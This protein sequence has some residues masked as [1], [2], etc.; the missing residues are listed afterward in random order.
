[1]EPAQALADLPR[2]NRPDAR[3]RLQI[4]LRRPDDRLQVAEAGDDLPDEVLGQ[5]GDVRQDPEAARRDR[6]VERVDVA[7]IADQLRQPLRFQQLPVRECVQSFERELRPRTG[8]VR[9]VV[10]HYGGTL[11]GHLADQLVQLHP[12]QPRLG[13]EL[14]AVALDLLG[15][16][17]RHLRAL[18]HDE[19]IVEHDGVLKL[20]RGQPRQDLVE[21]LPVGLERRER[22]IRL[23]E[24]LGHGIEL[25]TRLRDVHGD[26]GALLGDGDHERT[27]LLRDTLGSAVPRARLVRRD[28]RVGHQL[29][30]RV[31]DLRQR[32]RDDDRSVH[33][34]ELVE[35]LRREGLVEPHPTGE[36][37]RELTG[38]ADHDQRAFARADHVVDRLAELRPRRDALER[39]EQQ[40]IAARVVLRRRAREA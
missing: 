29:H 12:D 1:L 9:V 18:Q 20:E 17:R 33:L 31:R 3:D 36:E 30:V 10:V 2:A 34:R 35:E 21:P 27:G 38:I 15:H 24:D 6:M 14:D 5:A 4:A 13:A 16:P 25:V 23:R 32:R 19:D 11:G 28:R 26:R 7:R 8:S 39:V 40:R 37:K 22:L